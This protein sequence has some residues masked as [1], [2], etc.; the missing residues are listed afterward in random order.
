MNIYKA[1]INSWNIQHYSNLFNLIIFSIISFLYFITLFNTITGGDN[2]DFVITSVKG[3]IPH[4]PGYPLITIL[5]HAFIYLFPNTKNPAYQLNL[6]GGVFGS[7]VSIFIFASTYYLTNGS[8]LFS[9]LSCFLFCFSD[10][11]W[12]NSVQ[13][14]VF[15]LNNLLLSI[16]FYLLIKINYSYWKE[17]K[18]SCL[19]YSYLGSLFC[20]LA[21]CNQ[22]TCVFYIFP[23][24]LNVLYIL[25]SQN[26][27]FHPLS[28]SLNSTSLFI[29]G[30]SPYI[31]LYV[32]ALNPSLNSWGNTATLKGF[33]IHVLRQEYGTFQLYSDKSTDFSTR[34]KNFFHGLYLFFHFYDKSTYY[35]CLPF[36]F[37][38]MYI[39]IKPNSLHQRKEEKQIYSLKPLYVC[40]V[41]SFW[42][43]ICIFHFLANLPLELNPLY[44]G[45]QKR[46]WLQGLFLLSILTS[47]G[48]FHFCQLIHAFINKY[49]NKSINKNINPSSI[50][51]STSNSITSKRHSYITKVTTSIGYIILA[52]FMFLYIFPTYNHIHTITHNNYYLEYYAKSYISSL[53]KNSIY[54]LWG[55]LQ[56]YSITYLHECLHF[57]ED[58]LILSLSLASYDWFIPQQQRNLPGIVF[59]GIMY[60]PLG[61]KYKNCYNLKEFIDANIDN[62]DIYI[63]NW[64][65]GKDEPKEFY[66]LLPLGL[67]FKVVPKQFIGRNEWLDEAISSMPLF[68]LPSNPD[69]DSFDKLLVTEVWNAKYTFINFFLRSPNRYSLD[70]IHKRKSYETIEFMLIDTIQYNETIWDHYYE[71]YF[72]IGFIHQSLSQMIPAQYKHDS[73][74]TQFYSNYHICIMRDAFSIYSSFPLS[75]PNQKQQANKVYDYYT[76]QCNEFWR[77]YPQLR[78]NFTPTFIP[79]SIPNI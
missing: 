25:Y 32:G 24:I 35:V 10:V 19:Y 65:E 28:K 72:F 61:H 4:P 31:Y 43:Y 79:Q 67:G 48:L 55:D 76:K 68:Q 15:A 53:P 26:I 47:V 63:V 5:G 7:L 73:Q 49:T 40:I 22:H 41:F 23:W 57:R 21:L 36:A 9:S 70:D 46:F 2:A 59:P 42:F 56:Q 20:G 45:V 17:N 27:L 3:S 51:S 37:Y 8:L 11:T 14:E 60:H 16:I 69:D 71:G 39:Y 62:H 1:N 30:L 64:F 74:L 6:L 52:L 75:D 77:M 13:F 78:S 54:I 50:S 58:I 33:L 18:R 66:D 29:C 38:A 44:L 34:I 12:L